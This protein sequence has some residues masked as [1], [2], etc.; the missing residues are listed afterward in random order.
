MILRNKIDNINYNINHNLNKVE[1]I[2]VLLYLTGLSLYSIPVR[3]I[4]QLVGQLNKHFLHLAESVYLF[5]APR[6]VRYSW[7]VIK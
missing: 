1:Q 2:V 3:F 5:N 6:F 4:T 7:N